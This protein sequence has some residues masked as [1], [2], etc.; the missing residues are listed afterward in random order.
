MKIGPYDVMEEL[1]RGG[2][3]I[4]YR[5]RT[6]DGRDAALKVLVKADAGTFARFERERRLL[7]SLGEAQGFVGL[8][9]AGS[10]PGGPW[11]LMPFVPGGTLR[12]RLQAGPLGVEE[13]VALGAKQATALGAAHERGIVHRDVK[14]ENVLFAGDGRPLLADLGLAKHF[15]QGAPGASQ[16]VQ[17]SVRGAFKGTVGYMAPEQLVDAA[18]AGPPADVFAL[19]AVLYECLAGRPA[20]PGDT[21]L[22]VLVRVSSGTL[23][24]IGRPDVPPWLEGIVLRALARDPLERFAHGGSFAGALLGLPE[25]P[26][27]RPGSTKR[28]RRLAPLVAGG[29]LLAVAGVLAVLEERKQGAPATPPVARVEPERRAPVRPRVPRA[30]RLSAR[31]LVALAEE[32]IVASDRDGAIA[33]AT[34]AIEL[35]PKLAS[36]RANRASARY[37]KGDFD[38]AIEDATEAIRLDPGLALAWQARAEGRLRKGDVDGALGDA[39]EAIARDD[40][41][42]PAW[43]IRAEARGLEGDLEGAVEDATR[44]IELD[45]KLAEAW[46]SRSSARARLNQLGAAIADATRAIEL[47]PGLARAW[48]TRAVARGNDG[49]V[50]GALED[51]TRAIELDPRLGLAWRL[52]A[53]VRY[54]KGDFDGAI[55]DATAA[56]ALDA[57]DATARLTRGYARHKK[58]DL[59]GAIEDESGAIKIDPNLADAWRYRGY[60]REVKG[61]VSGA[62]ADY[63]R[64]LELAPKGRDSDVVRAS[65]EQ[66]RQRR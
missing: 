48:H 59:D 56:I 9:D 6:P 16:S 38:G 23:E 58:G 20:F 66:L 63:D 57:S 64:F 4:V 11:L 62:I 33:A 3:G 14:P 5:V 45:P 65:L 1:G 43:S 54:G 50:E 30:P 47:A 53:G 8:L 49:D 12:Q 61:D 27:A 44:A 13:T 28:V 52:R 35:D 2:A 19:G 41:A 22:D 37:G 46:S 26:Q 15:D 32:K 10:S 39:G 42:A 21:V 51:V 40:K 36:A 55:L 7:A 34:E 29:G 18:G 17:L 31:E 60:A 24:P 25:P